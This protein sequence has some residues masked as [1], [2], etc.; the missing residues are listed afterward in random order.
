LLDRDVA[1]VVDVPVVCRGFT[2]PD[3]VLGGF[4]L[5]R[6]RAFRNLPYIAAVEEG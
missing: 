5:S 3:V 4:G 2:A 1:R 6:W